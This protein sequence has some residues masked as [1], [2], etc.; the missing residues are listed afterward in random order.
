MWGMGESSPMGPMD[1]SDGMPTYPCP[2]CGAN[3]NPVEPKEEVKEKRKL[4]CCVQCHHTLKGYK[5]SPG[6]MET[7]LVCM[8]PQ[9]PNYSLLQA[10]GYLD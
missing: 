1:A 7:F 3:A 6:Q 4:R 9:C 2:E 5:Y 10:G 8:Q